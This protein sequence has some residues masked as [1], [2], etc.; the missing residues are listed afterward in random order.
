VFSAAGGPNAPNSPSPAVVDA[1]P[2][3]A[4]GTANAFDTSGQSTVL[5]SGNIYS[6]GAA[7]H[8]N[9]AVPEHGLGAGYVTTVLLQTRTQ[10]SEPIYA[11][12]GGY[13]L[14]YADGSGSHTL[15]PVSAAEVNRQPLGGFGGALVEYAALFQV[16]FS[17]G[18]LTINFDAAGSSM[19]FDR[20]SVDTIVTRASSGSELLGGMNAAV[21]FVPQAVPEPAG[22]GAVALAAVTL[23]SRRRRRVRNVLT[24]VNATQRRAHA[25]I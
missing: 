1:A 21:G 2:H 12:A 5:G 10:G 17:P 18:L 23:C 7:L 6:S 24:G 11:G 20:A 19:S 22:L 25:T 8:V 13:R 4:N 3:N 15:L 14:T 9:V 16:P